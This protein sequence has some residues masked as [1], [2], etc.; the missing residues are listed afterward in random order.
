MRILPPSKYWWRPFL[1]V[2][3]I[4][5]IAFLLIG[6]PTWWATQIRYALAPVLKNRVRDDA[7]ILPKD[8]ESRFEIFLQMIDDESGVDIRFVLVPEVRGES[9]EDFSTRTA[10]ELG[11]GRD[12]GRRGLL[13][14]YDTSAHRL[15][16]EVGATMEPIITDAFAGYL[17]RE[18]VRNFFGTGNPSLGLRTTLFIVQHRL[19][20]AVLAFDDDPRVYQ[21]I[22][23]SRRL[24]LGGGASGDMRVDRA[25]AFLNRQ[26]GSSP[27]ARA[28]FSP[29]PS[30]EAAHARFLE[31]LGRGGYETDVPLLTPESQRYMASLPM[32]RGYNDFILMSE[33]GQAY[34]VD[35]RGGLAM[36]YF[37]TNPLLSPHFFRRTPEG[38]TID[39]FAE[40][41][42]TRNYSGYWYTWGLVESGDDFAT[43]FADRYLDMSGVLRVAGGDNRPLP[44]KAF[45]D[46]TLWPAPHPEDSLVRVTVEE[47]TARIAEVHGRSVI[48]LYDRAS[49]KELAMVAARCRAAGAEVLAFYTD[50]EAQDVWNLPQALAYVR[51]PFAAVHLEDWRPGEL[52]IAMQPVGVRVGKRVGDT[53]GPPIVAVRDGANGVL[54]QTEGIRELERG[55]GELVAA[56]ER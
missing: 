6:P 51:A 55:A 14:I 44:A 9:L 22:E 20:R 50:Q 3:L 13:F 40:L 42:N 7:G 54:L 16:L 19:R 48:M 56:C 18:H 41:R 39:I 45:P 36:A 47:A 1:L 5:A 29:Q 24:A 23:D 53:W 21:F 10:R 46:V 30:P 31:W 33:Y 43:T 17:I 26:S 37:T 4:L 34:R 2:A 8:D 27:E 38:W 11:V 49:W 12:A 15:R 35:T 25:E 52:R 28:Y 32:T